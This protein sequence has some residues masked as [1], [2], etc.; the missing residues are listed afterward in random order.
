M[1]LENPTLTERMEIRKAFAEMD[2]QVVL[3]T[4]WENDDGTFAADVD[5]VIYEDA[6]PSDL[7]RTL[8]EI[9]DGDA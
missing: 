7:L 2:Q 8:V 9:L 4:V 3:I 5:G 6:S 1:R